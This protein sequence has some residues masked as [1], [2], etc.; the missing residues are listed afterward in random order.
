M[1]RLFNKLST[2][3]FSGISLKV[4]SQQ[5]VATILHKLLRASDDPL[6]ICSYLCFI[7]N[8]CHCPIFILYLCNE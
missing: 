1:C 4:G 2:I 7:I 5:P 8:I 3:S 6:H